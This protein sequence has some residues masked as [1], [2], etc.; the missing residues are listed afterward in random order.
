MLTCPWAKHDA[1]HIPKGK[2]VRLVCRFHWSSK[3]FDVVIDDE[4]MMERV[5]M[6]DSDG[7]DGV[8]TLDVFPRTDVV[9]CY[10][11]MHFFR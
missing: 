7:V 11:N 10:A 8:G 6:R 1:V 5:P 9:L 4:T 2:W 3:E